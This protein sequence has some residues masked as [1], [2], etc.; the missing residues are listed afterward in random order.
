MGRNH[1]LV[2]REGWVLLLQTNV[3]CCLS[4][5]GVWA[6]VV[7]LLRPTRAAFAQPP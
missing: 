3:V 7:S 4:R 2:V 6:I 1:L 5:V